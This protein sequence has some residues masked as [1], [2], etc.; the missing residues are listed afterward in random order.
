MYTKMISNKSILNIM[1]FVVCVIMLYSVSFYI[2]FIDDDSWYS[3]LYLKL[4]ILYACITTLV[5]QILELSIKNIVATNF[6][7][8]NVLGQ[9]GRIFNVLKVVSYITML[10]LFGVYVSKLMFAIY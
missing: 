5:S 10:I 7:I 2:D 3:T 9:L 4:F 6:I 1:I 8:E